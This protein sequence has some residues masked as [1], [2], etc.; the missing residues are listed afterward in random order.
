MENLPA[1]GLKTN[2]KSLKEHLGT[3]EVIQDPR[4]R[5]YTTHLREMVEIGS[6]HTFAEEPTYTIRIHHLSIR[7]LPLETIYDHCNKWLCTS[8]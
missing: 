3:N 8:F 6:S 2:S 1:I 4:F 5:T 7:Y